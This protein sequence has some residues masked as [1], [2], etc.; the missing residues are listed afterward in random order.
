MKGYLAKQK[1]LKTIMTEKIWINLAYF[2]GLHARV[3]SDALL[4]ITRA[5]RTFKVKRLIR[6]RE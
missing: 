4:V 5:Y 6:A 2:D 3:V 1:K